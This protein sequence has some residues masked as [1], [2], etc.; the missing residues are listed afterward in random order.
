MHTLQH[1]HVK[2]KWKHFWSSGFGTIFGEL[3]DTE[4]RTT[5]FPCWIGMTKGKVLSYGFNQQSN[6]IRCEDRY[7]K[8]KPNEHFTY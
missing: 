1:I 3:S 5:N 6:T 8:P 2:V 7:Q 4:Q